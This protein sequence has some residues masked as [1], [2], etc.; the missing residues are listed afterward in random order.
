MNIII[1]GNPGSGKGTVC[2]KLVD[3]FDYQLISAGDLLRQEIKSGSKLGQQ[4]SSIIDVGNLVPDKLI[5][6]IIFNEFAKPI[7][8]GRSYLIDGYPRTEKQAIHL[9]G[10]INVPIVLWLN[11]S[12]ETTIKRNLKR[13]ETSGRPDDSN[14]EIIK[15]RI[16]NYKQQVSGLRHFYE[17]IIVDIDGEGTPDE[18]YRSIIDT[19]FDTVIE[20]KDISDII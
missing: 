5:S 19:L 1:L 12:D 14:I 7:R 6:S 16:E 10:M 4:I 18:V 2:K 8:L 3:E 15:T 17:N 11:V 13:G 9:D 20:P